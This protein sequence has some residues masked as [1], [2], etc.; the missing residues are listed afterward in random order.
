MI[1]DAMPTYNIE[2]AD[3][4][5]LLKVLHKM[6]NKQGEDQQQPKKETPVVDN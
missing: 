5:V 2:I 6:E 4:N 3:R 1:F